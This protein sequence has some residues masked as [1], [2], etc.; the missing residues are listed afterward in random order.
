MPDVLTGSW[1]QITGNATFSAAGPADAPD[2]LPTGGVTLGGSP[3]IDY[4]IQFHTASGLVTLPTG[5]AGKDA[6]LFGINGYSV[7]FTQTVNIGSAG[8]GVGKAKLGTLSLS[9]DGSGLD[10][11]LLQQIL[12]ATGGPA[13]Y[14]EVDVV[15]YLHT[16]GSKSRPPLVSEYSFGVATASGLTTDGQGNS[17]LQIDYEAA[18]LQQ[19]T[20]LPSG[21]LVADPSGMWDQ[22]ANINQF[23]TIGPLTWNNPASAPATLPTTGVSDLGLGDLDYY[24]RF[25]DMQGHTLTIGG[26]Q[27]FPILDF[28]AGWVAPPGGEVQAQRTT[29]S[30]DSAALDPTL[31]QLL[32]SGAAF[33]EIDVLGYNA[34]GNLALDQSYG[35]AFGVSLTTGATGPARYEIEYGSVELQESGPKADGTRFDYP[36]ASVNFISD[37]SGFTSSANGSSD[38]PAAAPQTLPIDQVAAAG[39]HDISYYVRFITNTGAVLTLDG[40]QFF[41]L[42]GYTIGAIEPVSFGVGGSGGGA[43]KA[44][45]GPGT[46][47]FAHA[48]LDP[49]LFSIMAGARSFAEI[50]ILGYEP[51]NTGKAAVLVSEQSLG[52]VYGTSLTVDP[53]GV[54]Q[55][56]VEFGSIESQYSQQNADGSLS[57]EPSGSWNQI[58][59]SPSFSTNGTTASAPAKAPSSLPGTGVARQDSPDEVRYYVQFITSQGTLAFDGAT[60]VALTD[61]TAGAAVPV[62]VGGS[63]SG[64]AGRLTF[65]PLSL[66]LDSY[67]Q[68]QLFGSMARSLQFTEVDVVGF[69]VHTGSLVS[70][71]SYGQ[72]FGTSLQIGNTGTVDLQIV[73]NS[74]ESQH[75][76]VVGKN[77]VT[78]PS[79][80]WTMS[81][82]TAAFRSGSGATSPVTAPTTE[83]SPST[84]TVQPGGESDYYVRFIKAD[85]SVLTVDGSQYF[86]VN[87]FNTGLTEPVNLVVGGASGRAELDSLSLTLSDPELDP[88]LFSMLASGAA[89][90]EV[91][92]LGYAV[93]DGKLLSDTSF[94]LVRGDSLTIDNSGIAT[95]EATYA[96]AELRQNSVNS[97]TGSLVADPSG[98]FNQI[99]NTAEFTTNG[100]DSANPASAPLTLPNKGVWSGNPDGLEYYARFIVNS[101]ETLTI[102]D[103]N[104]F[105]L[106]GFN[107]NTTQPVTVSS[108]TGEAAGRTTFSPLDFTLADPSLSSTLLTMLGKGAMFQEVDILGYDR[109]SS[110]LVSDA[111]FGKVA[112]SS[113]TLD[114]SGLAQAEMQ[115]G[116]LELQQ[117]SGTACYA[118]GTRIRTVRGDVAIEALREGDRIVTHTGSVRPVR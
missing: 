115:Y 55:F 108:G 61:Y 75:S 73:Y 42:E 60:Y 19:K 25:I 76:S 81:T 6:N 65:D 18:E 111:S 103:V 86:A 69:D 56:E 93:T 116:A 101:S 33:G 102:N 91:D 74:M 52:L 57:V 113:L 12:S 80:A 34:A 38:T 107:F 14:T 117:S 51:P 23:T 58:T 1:N 29:L 49:T 46:L 95:Y 90:K 28:N 118:A 3:A 59:N 13:P 45:L 82:G 24:V 10:D 100:V 84:S 7:T 48:A 2:T 40:D 20:V 39:P 97:N 70:Q 44:E 26:A 8:S 78:D 32:A 112:T 4:Y 83:P 5:V 77:I 98:A 110:R 11:T 21:S 109:D 36:A 15:G 68:S 106:D 63:Q 79:F 64:E 30:L 35:V 47:S 67:V 94:G 96:A 104:L 43:G 31:L 66:T 17:V 114:Q 16:S 50:D 88:V 89:F 41:A 87:N 99:M 53:N 72:A 54:S 105:A 22:A 92:V 9:L 37:S 27:L 71:D 85:G 62:A